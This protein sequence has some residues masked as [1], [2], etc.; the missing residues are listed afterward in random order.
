MDSKIKILKGCVAGSQWSIVQVSYVHFY[1]IWNRTAIKPCG[2]VHTKK[3]IKQIV[4]FRLDF[5]I[6]SHNR[7]ATFRVVTLC[8]DFA[9]IWYRLIYWCE[10]ILVGTQD[11]LFRSLTKFFPRYDSYFL[12]H[13]IDKNTNLLS[14]L[15]TIWFHV[16][17]VCTGAWNKRTLPFQP[18]FLIL[19]SSSA[20]VIRL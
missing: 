7:S 4:Y 9:A 17:K 13:V 10:V 15:P 11:V 5:W 16:G 8:C 18:A 3:L 1:L 19:V 12:Q 6:N 20:F 14:F 2:M